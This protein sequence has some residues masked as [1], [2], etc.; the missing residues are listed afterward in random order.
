M[1][2]A[3]SNDLF[4]SSVTQALLGS[5]SYHGFHCTDEDSES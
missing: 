2:G 3:I 4:E 5:R 1:A